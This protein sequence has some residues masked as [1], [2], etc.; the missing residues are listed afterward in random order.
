MSRVYE[1]LNPTEAHGLQPWVS[2]DV[3]ALLR[4]NVVSRVPLSLDGLTFVADKLESIIEFE[5]RLNPAWQLLHDE[6]IKIAKIR[7]IISK[8]HK[9]IDGVPQDAKFDMA[10]AIQEIDKIVSEEGGNNVTQV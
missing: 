8:T 9:W 4:R 5:R 10:K 7:N 1:P 3:V 6:K 2:H